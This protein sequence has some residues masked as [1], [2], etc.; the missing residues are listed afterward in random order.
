MV[1]PKFPHDDKPTSQDLAVKIDPSCA[2]L[3]LTFSTRLCT[4]EDLVNRCKSLMVL[5]AFLCLGLGAIVVSAQVQLTIDATK[6]PSPPLRA[7]GPFP[8][9]SSPGH[10]AAL[11]IR[12]ELLVPTGKLRSDG[13]ILVDFIVTNV[14]AMAITLPSSTDQ[15]L[16]GTEILTL[17][18][19]SD[20]VKDAYVD[21]K[22]GRPLK[23]FGVVETSA[24]L[25]S[26][27]DETKSVHLLAPNE[28]MQVHASSRVGL[29]PGTDLLVA[30]AEL[31]RLSQ[32]A[33]ELVGTADSEAVTKPLSPEVSTAR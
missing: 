32:G 7:H 17:W 23:L 11:P 30:H 3:R 16:G 21:L 31:I 24:E 22:T 9:S 6:Q 18:L 8:G 28:T 5:V 33:S 25:Y 26:R 15:N 27:T 13:T 14:G 19:T 12:L 20:A 4:D 10:S 1:D 29:R 2:I